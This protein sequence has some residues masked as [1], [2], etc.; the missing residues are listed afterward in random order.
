MV[1]DWK[2]ERREP[3]P[4]DLW[5]QSFTYGNVE[6]ATS[7]QQVQVR[8]RNTGGKPY[9]R[10]EAHLLY[11]VANPTAA[12]VTFGWSED[13]GKVRESTQ[14]VKS[15]HEEQTWSID[16]SGEVKTQWVEIAVP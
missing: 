7:P 4:A 9:R 10:V 2:I 11:Q 15:S 16:T 5:S 1:S 3:E 14:L 6:L 12:K 8:F 13:G